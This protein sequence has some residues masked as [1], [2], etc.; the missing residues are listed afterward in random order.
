MI[1]L[2]HSTGV[3]TPRILSLNISELSKLPMDTSRLPPSVQNKGKTRFR[4]NY[5]WSRKKG[6]LLEFL[7]LYDLL[8]LGNI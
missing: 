8:V 1:Y 4:I 5:V 6:A 7:A 3:M 2:N